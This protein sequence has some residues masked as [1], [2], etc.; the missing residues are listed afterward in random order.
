MGSWERT[1]LKPRP[2]NL[3]QTIRSN[4]LGYAGKVLIVGFAYYAAA[5][6]GLRVALIERN[7]TPL[8]PPT[9]I[10][11][12]AFLVYGRA[13]WPGVALAAFAV[14]L[15]ISTNAL[16]AG[17]TAAG[18][19]LAPLVAVSL[20]VSVGFRREI[21]R[22]W[23]AVD[24]VFL[25]ALLSM[26]ISA[27]VGAGTLVL[28]GAISANEFPGA[29]AVWWTGDAMGVLVVAPFLLS[30]FQR[31]WSGS[32]RERTEGAA[33]LFL[34]AV[35]SFLVMNTDRGLMFLVIPF[36][37]WTAWRFQQRG[38][39]PAALIAAGIASWAAAHDL[40][41]FRHGT[42]FEKMITLQSFDA[43]VAFSSLFFAALVTERIRDREALEHAAAELEERVTRR[44]IELS[45][46]NEL[47]KREI[48]ER[49]ESDRRLRQREG[50]L[51]ETQQAAQVG[52]WE[53]MIAEN[54][55]SWSD[56]MYRIHGHLPQ[57]FPLTF[58]KAVEQVVHDDIVRIRAN[59][60]AALERGR[61]QHLPDI[62]YRIVRPDG[63][64]R[65]LLGRAELNVGPNGQPLRMI[66]TVQDVTESK[67][68]EREHRIAETLQ[69]SLLPDRLP[70]IPGV[71][72]AA[73]YVPATTDLEVGGD[74][75]DVVQL[76]D[77]RVGLA[78]GDVAG[79]GLRAASTMGQ[80]RMAL[81]VCA[82]EERSPTRVVTRLRHLVRG[83]L[84]SDFATL[85]YLVF[86]P[87]SGA[88][89]FANA[90]HPPPLVV[91]GKEGAS[92]LEGGLG[93]PLGAVG[94]PDRY[95][96]V[97]YHLAAG[98]TLFLFTDGLVERRGATIRDGLDRLKALAA[99]SDEDLEAMCDHVLLSMVES[100]VSDDVALLALRPVRLASEPLLLRL[101]A[102]PYVLASLRQTL[103]RWLRE[104]E[105]SPQVANDI[106]I[107]CGE[108]CANVIQHAYG[109]KE[110]LL[111]VDLVLLDG[112]V[113]VTV[114]D[115]GTWRPIS[116]RDGGHGE[117]LMQGL[118]DSVN[119]NSG[120][121]G[122]IVQMKRRLQT[123]PHGERARAR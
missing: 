64:E 107:A 69:R 96:D 11:L 67:M 42:L 40:G 32:L 61:D 120:S 5:R 3:A 54:R 88:V 24:I 58:D 16:A 50:Q 73:R 8:W 111:E 117:R 26:L 27:S 34:V 55:V 63:A 33:L 44:T 19:T 4:P 60:K 89:R 105:A 48:A 94:F 66:G 43:T 119:V 56:E 2:G 30:L 110:G 38:A 72:L 71:L 106:L 86:D 65:V 99:A 20:L 93:P 39:A 121:G 97:T 83:Q 116:G 103:R 37:G 104:I 36:L 108:A 52:S 70:E 76:P 90:G 18:N 13:V 23:D 59:V 57:E 46:A 109:A 68:A 53:W 77:G 118:M 31:P 82:L 91:E 22:L 81:R 41:P 85:V 1:P 78:I 112:T 102:E 84:G 51:A 115:H 21:D 47:L 17:A 114:R 14:N 87:D 45:A 80:L 101:P 100:D 113:E 7:V 35:V 98:S 75:Y 123:G 95:L 122:T 25:G 79:H 29:W 62:E 74:W 6:L 10:A 28:S 49:H 15:P 9:G 92:Y 12:V